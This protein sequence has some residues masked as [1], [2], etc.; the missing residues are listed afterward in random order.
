[1]VPV[2]DSESVETGSW[3]TFIIGFDSASI[4]ALMISV[5]DCVAGQKIDQPT[6]VR[7][8]GSYSHRS[9]LQQI[10]L[11]GSSIHREET[12]LP[13]CLTIKLRLSPSLADN[14]DAKPF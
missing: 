9:Y 12:R 14:A 5:L 2:A 4:D 8:Y 3:E 13:F 11:T 1:M 6:G 10:V 7:P